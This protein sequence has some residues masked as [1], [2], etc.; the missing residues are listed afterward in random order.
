[1][2]PNQYA[3]L[4][5]DLVG[6]SRL[7]GE[8]SAQAM[9]WL[10]KVAME[11]SEL[12]PQSVIGKLDTFRHDSWQMLMKIPQLSLRAAVFLRAALMRNSESG[13]RGLQYDTR[14]SIGIGGAEY[15]AETRVSDSRGDAFTIS[16]KNLDAMKPARLE[17]GCH[18]CIPSG[19]GMLR[20]SVALLDC[21]V[22]DWTPREALAVYGALKGLTQEEIAESA[23]AN[24]HTGKVVTRQAIADSQRRA[25][26]RT[27]GRVLEEI[28]N[29]KLWDLQ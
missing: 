1:M 3:V 10:R 15:I 26:W 24:T 17:I 20:T 23:P 25:H 5:G 7:A 14:I 2:R 18:G 4:T 21:V 19:F 16:G 28:E 13:N 22:T 11:F 8:H 29:S 6:S 9:E 27:V 12:H